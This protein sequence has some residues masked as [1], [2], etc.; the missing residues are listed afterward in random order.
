MSQAPRPSAPQ[1]NPSV[2]FVVIALN[3]LDHA[4]GC[5]RAIL[6][7]KTDARFE[8]I[9]VDDGSTDGTTD[10]VATA[11]AGDERLRMVRFPENRGR[12]AARAAGVEAA[13]GRA[14]GFVDA[15]ITLPRDWLK[16]C[17]D[18]LP[19]NAAVGGIA[20]PDGDATVLAR[21]SGATPREVPGSSP[22]TGNNV[23][24][25]AAAFA[26]TGFDPRDRLGEDT[27]LSNRLLRAGYKL[28]RVPG[29]T[30]RH[31]ESKSYA[32]AIRWRFENGVDA[33]SLPRELGVIRFA[34]LVWA[35]WLAAWILG[36]A[37]AVVASSWWLL[38]GVAATVAAGVMHAVSRFRPRPFGA[39][40]LACLADVP[41]LAA[42]LAGRT[43][44]IPRLVFGR[45]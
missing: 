32:Q 6:A 35:G 17:L 20:V 24:F 34:D 18:E 8:L 22:I 11:A 31:E 26:E 13:R 38:L 27:R 9:F 44:G 40:L 4:P 7:Q 41:L 29:L 12:G 21:V 10:A 30:V 39:F 28:K 42:Y 37:L 1:P 43:V 25:D 16:R 14:I 5:V 33:A 15:D 36:V 3:E 23:L 45:R 19:G 2:S